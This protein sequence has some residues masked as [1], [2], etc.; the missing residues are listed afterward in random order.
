MAG[1]A[2]RLLRVRC[3]TWDQVEAFY[4]RKLRA[5]GR[6]TMKVGFATAVGAP[7]TLVLELPN[8]IALSVDGEVTSGEGEGKAVEVTL[9]G[10]TTALIS[11]LESLVADARSGALDPEA[12]DDEAR[13]LS[14]RR[15]ELTR[16]RRLPAHEVLG[17]P[18]DPSPHEL[19]SAWLALA[20]REHPDGVAR[21][22]S[23][24]LAAVAAEVMAVAG[25]AYDRIR[26]ALVADGRGVAIGPSLRPIGGWSRDDDGST[27][28]LAE[29]VTPPIA[30]DVEPWRTGPGPSVDEPSPLAPTS[31][32]PPPL[33]PALAIAPPL[34]PASASPAPAADVEPRRSAPQPAVSGELHEPGPMPMLISLPDDDEPDDDAVVARGGGPDVD[35]APEALAA[36]ATRPAQLLPL[37]AM[38][39][40]PHLMLPAP[41]NG[42]P[43]PLRSSAV[44]AA[45]TGADPASGARIGAGDR[46][47]R[48]VRQHISLGDH[49]SAAHLAE[50]ALQL[51]P[52]DR[53]LRG[54]AAVAGAMAAAARGDRLAA[55]AALEVATVAD[56]DC[57]EAA[58][59][60]AELRHAAVP[61]VA[62]IRRW[63]E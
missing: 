17:V 32:I 41:A 62:L 19:R 20:R 26:A 50:A 51:Y 56:P 34:A 27:A 24:A 52:D 3:A 54:L 6:L 7:V 15:G 28:F 29:A 23:P 4:R 21:Y 38:L 2:P 60:L 18:R 47:A 37:D 40:A 31:A 12:L 22:A 11:R 53:R 49:G 61:T 9:R 8:Q 59:A 25:A 42:E 13:L 36:E 57:G 5:G 30:S 43:P 10:L 1:P 45:V 58:T 39:S 44:M 16:L 35:A 55:V 48:Q 63:F 14:A 33:A 46:F